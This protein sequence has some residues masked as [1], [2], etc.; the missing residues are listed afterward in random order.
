VTTA[1]Q[2]LTNRANAQRSSGPKTISG[3][4]ASSRNARTHSLT[5]H[6]IGDQPQVAVERLA[7]AFAA[8]RQGEMVRHYALVAAE[9]TFEI[10][11]VRSI[12]A[13]MLGQIERS[14]GSAPPIVP[15]QDSRLREELI[16][17]VA[18]L[19]RYERRALS[20]RKSAMRSL[21]KLTS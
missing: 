5:S 4:L 17:R 21:E 12:R 14:D 11:R 19:E 15:R 1:R 10:A 2:K 3:K 16:G 18:R 6:P 20:R 13:G 9:S 8:G 7:H